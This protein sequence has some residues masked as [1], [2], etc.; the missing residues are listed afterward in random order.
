MNYILARMFMLLMDVTSNSDETTYINLLVDIGQIITTVVAVIS[1]LLVVKQLK[2]VNKSSKADVVIGL[3]NEYRNPKW[4]EIRDLIKDKGKDVK[5]DEVVNFSHMLNHIGFLLYH[6]YIDIKSLYQMLG[7]NT[8][9]TWEILSDDIRSIRKLDT[10]QNDYYPYQF[11]FQYL[12]NELHK[13][14]AKGKKEIEKLVQE[15]DEFE[16]KFI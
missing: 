6:G 5:F 8:M 12:N 16:N 13:Y 4:N 3:F 7:T 11:H 15:M 2:Q 10:N 1:L 9:E 14:S